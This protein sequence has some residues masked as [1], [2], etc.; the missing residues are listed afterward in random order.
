[1]GCGTAQGFYYS[2]PVPADAVPATVQRLGV[3]R[4]TASGDSLIE[5]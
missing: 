2:R 4:T 5:A 3:L 1:M